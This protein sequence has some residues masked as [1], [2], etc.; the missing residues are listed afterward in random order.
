MPWVRNATEHAHVSSA[1]DSA[2]GSVSSESPYDSCR[3]RENT[4]YAHQAW[5][6]QW[7]FVPLSDLIMYCINGQEHITN[8]F[9]ILMIIFYVT[10]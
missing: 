7:L 5:K 2:C 10:F 1:S 6:S 9:N 8:V 4:V 3:G